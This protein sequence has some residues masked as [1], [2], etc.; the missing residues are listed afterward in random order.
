M[1]FAAFDLNLLRVFHALMRERSVTR[2]GEQIGLSQP[3][4]SQALN[5]L[6]ALLDDQLFVR[7]GTEMAPTPR[8][9]AL[10]PV[11]R[12]A[13]AE[14]EAALQGDRRFDPASADRAYTLMGADY[15]SMLLMPPLF[16]R[17]AREAPKV[18]LR[19]VDTVR[20][21]VARLLQED[22]VDLAIEAPGATPDWVSR[23]VV[24]L[25]PF[26]FVAAR[27]LPALAGVEPEGAIP[28][29]LLCALPHAIRTTDG[30]LSGY[31]DAALAEAGRARR[32]ALGLPHFGAVALAC[33]QAG[34]VAALPEQFARACA[35]ALGL[36]VYQPPI[37]VPVPEISMYWHRRHDNNPAHAWLRQLVRE[38]IADV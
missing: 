32:V 23:E 27:G 4:V 14:L 29:D 26:V 8:A 3:A 25:S 30:S 34:L 12:G 37:P 11:V 5:R 9:E 36:A 1:N 13:L 22:A 20:G 35:P 19:L 18:R 17:V 38:V 6:R 7:R 21:E 16:A 10:A 31:L 33:A 15:V 28:L 24:F 2:A